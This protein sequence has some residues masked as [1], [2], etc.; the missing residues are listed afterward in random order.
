MSGSSKVLLS[1]HYYVSP[2]TLPATI[3]EL[4]QKVVAMAGRLTRYRNKH[5]GVNKI[6]FST[7]QQS[8]YKQLNKDSGS[9][10]RMLDGQ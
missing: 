7:D 5:K 8:L 6:F 2:N 1:S 10:V 9:D 4:K 3:E